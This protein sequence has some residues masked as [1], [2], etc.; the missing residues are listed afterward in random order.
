MTMTSATSPSRDGVVLDGTDDVALV[1][2]EARRALAL[3][4][5]RLRLGDWDLWVEIED[6]GVAMP[7]AAQCHTEWRVRRARITLPPDYLARIHGRTECLP[8]QDD[9]HLVEFAILHELLHVLEE[10]LVSRVDDEIRWYVGDRASG[11]IIGAE[12]RNSWSDSREWWINHVARA[13]IDA[14]ATS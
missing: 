11:G 9:A 8:D 14:Y 4:Q 12:L 7:H 13:L 10:P 6:I 1:L 3:W 5:T 2:A